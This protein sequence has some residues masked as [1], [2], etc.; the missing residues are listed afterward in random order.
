MMQRTKKLVILLL[1]L[2]FAMSVAILAACGGLHNPSQNGGNNNTTKTKVIVTYDAN[3]GAFADGNTFTQE[4]NEGS[5]LTAPTSPTRTNYTFAG[6]AKNK[7]GSDMW[8][9]DEDTVTSDTTLYAQWNQAAAALFSVEGASIDGT[10]VLLVVA[11]TVDSV[12]LSNKVV[13]SDGATWKLYYDMLGQTEI[14]TKVAVGA[15]GALR[16][17][18]NVFY[19]VVTSADGTQVNTY[20]LTVFRSFAITVSFYDGDNLLK[21]DK[22]YAGYEYTASYTS[23]FTG[24]T[25]ATWQDA[26]GNAFTSGILWQ[27]TSLYANKRAN[28]YT[29]TL[30]V[31]EGDELDSTTKTVTYDSSFTLPVPTREHYTFDGW[32]I[33]STRITYSNGKSVNAWNYTHDQMATARW[34]GD[35]STVTLSRNNSDAGTVSGGGSHNYNSQVTI[36]AK[37]NVGYTWIGWFDGETQLTNEL[38]YTF[39]MGLEALSFEARWSKVTVV[40]DE[41]TVN[42]LSNTYKVGDKVTLTVT[43]NLGYIVEGWYIGEQ[44]VADTS[45]YTY[46]MTD[47]DC[48]ITAKVEV[49]AEMSNFIFTSTATTCTIS[50]IIDSTIAELVVPEY[51]TSIAQG[52][53][54]DCS[55]LESISVQSGNAVYYSEDDCLIAISTKQL[56]RGCRN[57]VI[58]EGVQ[59]LGSYAFNGCGLTSI[60]IPSSV[61]SIGFGAFSDC[62]SLERIILPFVGATKNGTTN[63]HFG[64]IFGA[65]KYEENNEY[66]PTSL[67]EVAVT[68]CDSI[69]GS[70]FYGCNSLAKIT[71]PFVGA[72]KDGT[73]NTWLGYIWGATKFSDNSSYVP[74]SL[75]EVVI[76]DCTS[77]GDYAFYACANLT[78]I[79]IPSNVTSIGQSAFRGCSGLT[80]IT[81]PG[82]KIRSYAFYDCSNLTNIT[83][84]EGITSI[85]SYAFQNCGKLTSITIPTSVTT[86]GISAFFGCNNIAT[87]TL[88]FVGLIKDGT[89]ATHFGYIFG[90][91]KYND[92]GSFVPTSLKEVIITD[93]TSIGAYAFYGCNNLQR[94]TIPKS[95][96]SIMSAAFYG[97]SN[98]TVLNITDLA[99]WCNINFNG[100]EANPLYYV[101]NL[102]INNE[103]TTDLHIPNTVTAINDYVFYGWSSLT[104]ITFEK[105]INT[106]IGSYAFSD[107]TNLATVTFEE[108]SKLKS[109]G[110]YAF[111]NCGSLTSITVPGGAIGRSA[112]YGCS[113]LTSITMEGVTSIGSYAFSGCSELTNVILSDCSKLTS[114]GEAAFSGCS[115][116]TNVTL[117]DC[118]KLTSIGSYAFNGCS[119]LTDI[120]IPQS[121]TSIGYGA[122][123]NCGNLESITLPFVGS[124]KNGTSNTHFGYIFGED[125][126][127]YN[128]NI[129]T[130]LKEVI[131]TNCTS[132][133]DYAFYGCSSLTSIILPWNLKSIGNYAFSGCT[134]LTSITMLYVTTIGDC[135][136][137]NCSNLTSITIPST[138]ESLGKRM[139][140]YSGLTTVT[141]GAGIRLTSISDYAFQN[142]SNLKNITIP[143]SVTSIGQFAF[144]DCSELTSVIFAEGSKLTSIGMYAF[145][146]CSSL[147]S[148]TILSS[149][150]SIGQYAF[151]NCSSLKSVTFENPNGWWYAD[152]ASATRGTTITGLDSETTAAYYLTSTYRNYF[153]KRSA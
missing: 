84:L 25:L 52:A 11:E 93:C 8:K 146:G 151:F 99:A 139:F 9:F 68:D 73:N 31:N 85:G 75:K 23:D 55:N 76:T 90:A 104:N 13:C 82:G 127:T 121:V 79:T 50:G 48:T 134:E 45:T 152:S 71:L 15:S 102:Y 140:W 117:S 87:I 128:K 109:L 112:F 27:S 4:V 144:D 74:N 100:K 17:G 24:Y 14:P 136:F 78:S 33:G 120:T 107:C 2:V 28:T 95:L 111:N 142:C 113:K 66:V 46:T 53:L 89:S 26:N 135:A 51:V 10:E 37:T 147:T 5:K 98:L 6:W 38:S 63:I 59:S 145:S 91:S 97:C 61:T 65:S 40:C 56:I 106:S 20:T 49:A 101:H 150:T 141:F 54:S 44:K 81:I 123:R 92:N 70:A 129:T 64:Y 114:I 77:I 62:S 105:G 119:S 67:S 86:I 43:T 58:P 130:S 94:I 96:T 88:P 21:T 153:W 133:A 69:G 118:S 30:D 116:L 132:I 16:S 1:V 137:S 3:G 32:Y 35:S 47:E 72:T 124:T 29:V 143:S 7:S 125:S 34:T 19:I 138:V 41:G 103:L 131:I 12:G 110:E 42:G 108:D 60:S 22:A 149:V 122:F 57:S 80:S 148:I 36:T 39:T 115:E 83:M 126:Y 18:S